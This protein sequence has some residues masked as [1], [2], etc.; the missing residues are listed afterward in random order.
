[1]TI[2]NGMILLPLLV[3]FIGALAAGL[4][5][6]I[7]PNKYLGVAQQNILLAIAP[8][9]AFIYFVSWVTGFIDGN[10]YVYEFSWLPSLGLVFS[11]YVDSLSAVFAL[12]ITFIGFWVVIYTGQY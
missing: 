2:S 12:L 7:K 5:A 10:I 4:L 3:I 11:F 9:A 1:M 6:F 8:A